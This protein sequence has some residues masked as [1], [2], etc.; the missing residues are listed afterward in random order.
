MKP[1]LRSQD[2]DL[3]IRL[4]LISKAQNIFN[5]FFAPSLLPPFKFVYVDSSFNFI[6][7]LGIIFSENTFIGLTMSLGCRSSMMTF[8]CR[9]KA[10]YENFKVG[11][12]PL[13]YCRT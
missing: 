6:Q 13:G 2:T 12:H 3:N 9:D 1:R 5:P 7:R 11:V 4:H 10:S 8:V